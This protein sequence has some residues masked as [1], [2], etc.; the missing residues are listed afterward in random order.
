M[1][2]YKELLGQVKQLTPEERLALIEPTTQKLKEDLHAH[3]SE[4][5]PNMGRSSRLVVFKSIEELRSLNP[6]N[7]QYSEEELADLKFSYLAEKY[8]LKLA[9]V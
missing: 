4:E 7:R 3:K 8:G 9:E 1:L 2:T 5:L 6:Q